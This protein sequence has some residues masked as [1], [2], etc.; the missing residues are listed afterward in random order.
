[1]T[2]ASHRTW[3]A[4]LIG[5]ALLASLGGCVVRP[6]P[7]DVKLVGLTVQPILEGNE[8]SDASPVAWESHEMP[9]FDALERPIYYYFDI[10]VTGGHEGRGKGMVSMT[11]ARIA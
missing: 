10:D 8:T 1:M 5:V 6:L 11:L 3:A 7:K 9:P 2:T 4:R